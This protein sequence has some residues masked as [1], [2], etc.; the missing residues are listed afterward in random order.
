MQ[1]ELAALLVDISADVSRLQRDL[2]DD[3]EIAA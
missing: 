1:Q 2:D 3:Q